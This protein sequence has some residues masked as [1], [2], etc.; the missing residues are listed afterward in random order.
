MG[1]KT[2]NYTIADK[3]LTLDTAYAQVES[4]HTD[5]AGNC[6]AFIKVQTSRAAMSLA[7]LETKEVN[8]V[9]DKSLPL[10]EQVYTAA[11]A[12]MFSGWEDDIPEGAVE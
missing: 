7:A 9:A 5:L 10:Y 3:G 8:L 2:T 1:L 6:K 11:K 12:D 4:L